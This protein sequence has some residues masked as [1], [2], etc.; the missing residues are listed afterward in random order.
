MHIHAIAY[1]PAGQFCHR[2]TRN[3]QTW[4]QNRGISVV[5]LC[6]PSRQHW[7]AGKDISL[8]LLCLM[9]LMQCM[10]LFVARWIG[11]C[12]RRSLMINDR[13]II[14]MQSR[15][16][17]WT[18]LHFRDFNLHLIEQSEGFHLGNQHPYLAALSLPEDSWL[19]FAPCLAGESSSS[20]L[21]DNLVAGSHHKLG[22]LWG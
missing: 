9:T 14:S 19:R 3:L 17:P 20:S 7:W 21:C 2:L 16:T 12:D 18:L 8:L 1:Y 15:T 13:F 4:P 6:N 10:T 5:C 11:W 22:C